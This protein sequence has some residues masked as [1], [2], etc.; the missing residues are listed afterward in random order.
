MSLESVWSSRLWELW[1]R[2]SWICTSAGSTRGNSTAHPAWRPRTNL[3]N[4]K[5]GSFQPARKGF[6][7]EAALVAGVIAIGFAVRV[8]DVDGKAFW[9][10]EAESA[11]YALT[12]SQQSYPTDT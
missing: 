10:D 3:K 6:L 4:P 12:V 9:V 1:R 5:T 2:R 7:P 11:I 8:W